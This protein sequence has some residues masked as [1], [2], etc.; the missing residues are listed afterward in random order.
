M[1][2]NVIR[3]D[4][5]VRIAYDTF[6]DPTDPPMLLIQGLGAHYLGWHHE[7]C[8]LL[9][10]AGY[11]VLRH[12]NRDIGLSDKFPY[13]GYNL[14]DMA[15]D[16]VGLLSALDITSAHIVGQ[17]MGGMIAQQ[18]AISHPDRVR[19]LALI[20]TAA[21]TAHIRSDVAA[22]RADLPDASTRTEA[23][24]R[25]LLN[26]S[27]C[28]SAQYPHDEDWLRRLGS[29]MFDRDNDLDATDRQYAAIASSPDRLD[30][31]R[32][33]GIPTAIIHGSED[34]LIDPSAA[35]ELHATL[36]TSTLTIYPGMG[37][38]LP[39]PLWRDI[40]NTISG[41]AFASVSS[42]AVGATHR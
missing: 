3:T 32:H 20:Y 35:H 10:D 27:P 4:S 9:A 37:H 29:E 8:E 12:D 6:G 21:N 41:N 13:G 33:V 5:G 23:V 39:R 31:L 24:A 25:Y 16:S 18:I 26:E 28:A 17:S 34:R 14:A 15:A 38:S 22:E 2:N 1:S 40:V 30:D 7:L 36:P 19:S 42:E 11:Y